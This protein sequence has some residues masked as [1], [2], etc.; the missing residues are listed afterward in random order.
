SSIFL[1]I[2]IIITTFGNLL[3]IITI[4]RIREFNSWSNYL[5][6]SIT[7]KYLMISFV[8]MPITAYMDVFYLSDWI[9][10][11]NSCDTYYCL[12]MNYL[13]F[14]RRVNIH[15][16][17]V[18][19]LKLKINCLLIK[20]KTNVELKKKCKNISKLWLQI[21]KDMDTEVNKRYKL[22]RKEFRVAYIQAIVVFIYIICFLPF[23]VTL[24]IIDI[25][26]LTYIPKFTLSLTFWLLLCNSGVNPIVFVLLNNNFR[27]AFKNII[28]ITPIRQKT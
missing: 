24:L 22:L 5:I 12:Q 16:M 26:S 7:L 21:K 23:F 9:W 2:I 14:E 18:N 17:S 27:N 8:I 28:K 25:N 11:P 1:L 3:T 4:I 15:N 10:G 20:D 13:K 19:E 6:L